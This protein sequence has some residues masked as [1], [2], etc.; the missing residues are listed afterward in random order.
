MHTREEAK[1]VSGDRSVQCDVCLKYLS[2]PGYLERHKRKHTKEPLPY[3]CHQCPKSFVRMESLKKHMIMC[4]RSSKELPELI[5][6]PNGEGAAN[7]PEIME[8]D[9]QVVSCEIKI[10]EPDCTD[11]DRVEVELDY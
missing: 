5:G 11:Q 7:F 9:S 1:E 2:G 10:E 4:G 6:N 8:D 3:Q